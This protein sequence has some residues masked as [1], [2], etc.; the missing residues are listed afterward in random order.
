MYAY[1][2]IYLYMYKYF[3][4]FLLTACNTLSYERDAQQLKRVQIKIPL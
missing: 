2:H 3:D 1:M 4:I